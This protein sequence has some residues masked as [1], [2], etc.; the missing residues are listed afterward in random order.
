[1]KILISAITCNPYSGSESYFGWSAVQCLSKDHE[2]WVLTSSR[3]QSDLEHAKSHAVVP[4]NVRFAFLGGPFKPW[5]AN[6][7][8]A[9]FQNWKEYYSFSA[10]CLAVA[11]ELHRKVQFDLVHHVTVATWRV[12]SPLWKLG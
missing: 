6:R 4:Q 1:M 5:H 8:I 12:G 9:R 7:W 11:R 3:N 10:K 2:L